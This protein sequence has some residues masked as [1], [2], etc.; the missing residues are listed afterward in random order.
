[1]DANG[2]ESGHGPADPR[3]FS[4]TRP[5]RRVFTSAEAHALGL[6]RAALR[7]GE[8]QGR[9][10]KIERRIYADG[11]EPISPYDRAIGAVA[12]SGGV[13]SGMVA[14]WLLGLDAVDVCGPDV[15][16]PPDRSG[17][18]P[19]ARRRMLPPDRIIVVDGIACTDGLQ[20]LIDLA[21]GMSDDGW[22]QVLESA[23][24]LRLTSIA[25]IEA[26][27]P[28][29]SRTRARGVARIRRVL[30]RRPP[31]APPTESLLETLMV[32]LARRV[33]G[34]PPPERQYEVFDADGLFVARVDLVWSK[35]GMFAELDGQHHKGQPVHDARRETA[36]VAATGWLPGRFTWREVVHL[37]VVTSRRLGAIADQAR[38]RTG[39]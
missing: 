13:A 38:R 25:E 15:T 37:P 4:S 26:T 6:T 34:L 12:A 5:R 7:W 32:Q 23:L 14:G 21:A 33:P 39:E 17:G 2:R 35:I 28:E 3:P 19:G 30:A 1:M 29:L 11:P 9:W 36:V 27:L 18:R 31:G 20:T 10:T 16:V 8:A 22:E 24:R